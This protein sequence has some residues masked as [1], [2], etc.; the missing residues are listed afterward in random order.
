MKPPRP[1]SWAVFGLVAGLVACSH[2]GGAT[3]Q[4]PAPAP[5]AAAPAGGGALNTLTAAERAAGWRLLFDGRTT[6]GWRGF[7]KRAVP[8]GWQVVD[9]AL[10]RT[11]DGGD[12]VTTQTFKN[13]ELTLEWKVAPGGNSGIFYRASEDDDEIYW[14]APEMQVLDDA[15]HPDGKSR[16][17]AAGSDYALYPA[18]AGIVKP[19]GE[20]NQ[21][22]IIVNGRHVEH[23]LNGVRVVQ[24]ELWSP[25]WEVK[26][27]GSKFAPH[28]HYGRNT[29][30]YIGLQDHGDWVAF[31]NIKIKVLP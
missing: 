25:D 12:L 8:S 17:T 15:R 28:P 22:R 19:A 31:R 29:E 11:G 2:A 26:V 9:G 21:V 1:C 7:K 3:D 4:T 14:T 13:F 20:W 10:T 27:A 16:L 30:G 5:S 6:D 24:Y 18:P 23:W